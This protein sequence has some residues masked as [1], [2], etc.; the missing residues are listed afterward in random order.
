VSNSK[1]P[2]IIDRQTIYFASS[3]N[4][5]EIP[6]GS[7]DVIITSPPYNR[8]KHYSSDSEEIHND[9]LPL[10]EYLNFLKRVW[11]ECFRTGSQKCI[12]F[13]NI[14]DSATD[15]GI[16][17]KVVESAV[18]AG[19]N[20][21]QDIIW[22]KSI[23]GKGHYT[24]SGGNKRFNNV[25]EHIY[26]LVKNPKEYVLDPKAVG[27]PYADKSN[28][29]RYG[30]EDLRDPGNIVHIC[31]EKTT[32]ATI[33][34]GHDAPYPIGLPYF[35]LKA[36]PSP[37]NVLD[38]FLGTGTTL[39]ASHFLG[40]PGYG[41]E[42]F[43][44]SDLIKQTVLDGANFHPEPIVLIPHYEESINCLIK[45][46]EKL[47]NRQ[48]K[49]DG[50]IKS[51]LLKDLMPKSKKETGQFAILIDTLKK[52]NPNSVLFE[53]LESDFISNIEIDANRIRNSEKPT[54]QKGK[55]NCP[56]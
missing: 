2:L 36:V 30:D 9:N 1:D 35:C 4:M 26:L 22:V 37:L 29:G 18:E 3:E 33:K 23:Y 20:R 53:L 5:K 16:S 19:W 51:E 10:Q 32:G 46:V 55:N 44:R 45:L 54:K 17:E 40:I 12:F 42:K 38:P 49:S 41:Y 31:Y 39:A 24:P 6:A 34:K 56:N 52:T 25:W 28:I 11:R 43:P 21:I 47:I 13:L 48:L 7:I 15:Q 50:C 8:N 27:I 14:G